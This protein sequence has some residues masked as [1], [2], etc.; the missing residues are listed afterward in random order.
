MANLGFTEEI[1]KR[2]S[3]NDNRY[4]HSQWAY[5]LTY[6][7][8]AALRPNLQLELVARRPLLPTKSVQIE[9][10]ADRLS[11]SVG[12]SPRAVVVAVAETLAEKILSFLRRF[13]MHRTGQMRQA[14]DTALVR[15]IYDSHC[16]VQQTPAAVD[17][18][19]EA[20]V[21]LA[22]VDVEEFGYQDSAFAA[23]PKT[24]MAAALQAAGRDSQTRG[25]YERNLLPLVSI[26][27]LSDASASRLGQGGASSATAPVRSQILAFTR[28]F[29]PRDRFGRINGHTG[30]QR[31]ADSG[32]NRSLPSEL[33]RHLQVV[34]SNARGGRP[35]QLRFPT[36]RLSPVRS[37]R[38]RFAEL[39]T[40]PRRRC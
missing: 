8:I 20:F 34:L 28:G 36:R 24:V 21:P 5:R 30:S 6:G 17:A 31:L 22:M 27:E 10:L 16:I 38:G 26:R 18:A 9:S 7:G 15:H 4:M 29:R 40:G 13:A 12:H 35:E 14:W 11:H 32:R 25:E 33:G 1:D 2:R 19:R 39:C 23:N 37:Q 3:L